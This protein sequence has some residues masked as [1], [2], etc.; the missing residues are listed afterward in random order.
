M[1]CYLMNLLYR[2]WFRKLPVLKTNYLDE[3]PSLMVGCGTRLTK[4][5]SI[6]IAAE[7]IRMIKPIPHLLVDSFLEVFESKGHIRDWLQARKNSG[8]STIQLMSQAMWLVDRLPEGQTDTDARRDHVTGFLGMIGELFG[9]T[10]DIH[11][12]ISQS[13]EDSIDKEDA[14]EHSPFTLASLESSSPLPTPPIRQVL[15]PAPD[16]EYQ[17]PYIHKPVKMGFLNLLK[18]FPQGNSGETLVQ[19]TIIS[20]PVA[21]VPPFF[22]VCNA[23]LKSYRRNSLILIDGQSFLVPEA[24]EVFLRRVRDSIDEQLF[25]IWRICWY[26]QDAHVLGDERGIAALITYTSQV[27]IISSLCAGFIDMY[28][29]LTEAAEEVAHELEGV[30]DGDDWLLDLLDE[31][32]VNDA[33]ATEQSEEE[34]NKMYVP[35]FW[36]CYL[37]LM[38]IVGTR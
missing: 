27:A 4:W 14:R 29:I 1:L 34:K 21:D 33:P 31:A 5:V 18:L 11:E 12:I 20:F 10:S 30:L 35:I 8:F 36:R 19:G 6:K 25:F 17:A 23:T 15:D 2:S 32:Q 13:I 26:P 22:L 28:D 9:L 38:G 3:I 16:P 7:R 24:L 37:S